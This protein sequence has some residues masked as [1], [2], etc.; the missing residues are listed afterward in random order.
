MVRHA[1]SDAPWAE[2]RLGPKRIAWAYAWRKFFRAGVRFAG[3]S[4][5][6]VESERPLLSIYAAITRRADR[7]PPARMGRGA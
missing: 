6:P 1:T 5:F 7:I 3:G 2:K 4:D